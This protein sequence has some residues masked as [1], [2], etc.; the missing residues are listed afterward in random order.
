MMTMILT[1]LC[2]KTPFYDIIK[3]RVYT[4]SWIYQWIKFLIIFLTAVLRK[5]NHNIT[6]WRINIYV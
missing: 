2:K 6:K 4:Y 3:K 1:Y 5:T